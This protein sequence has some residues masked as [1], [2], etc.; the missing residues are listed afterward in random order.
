V[1]G[2]E[3]QQTGTDP[4]R[5]RRVRHAADFRLIEGAVNAECLVRVPDSEW[6][7][8]TGMVSPSHPSGRLPAVHAGSGRVVAAYPR[9]GGDA[10]DTATFG[11][12]APPSPDVFNAHGASLRIGGDGR[13]TLYVVNHGGREAVEVFE[14]ETVGEEAPVVT[15][16]GAVPGPPGADLNNPSAHPDGGFV[17][18][19]VCQGGR[20]S[21]P[22]LWAGDVTGCVLRWTGPGEEMTPIPGTELNAPNGTELSADGSWLF[23]A[24]Y[25][26]H[27]IMRLSLTDHDEPP[28]VTPVDYCPDNFTWTSDGEKLIVL[29]QKVEPKKLMAA[30]PDNDRYDFGFQVL[31]VDPETLEAVVLGEF[32]DSWAGPSTA[33]AVDDEIWVSSPRS[34]SLL[35]VPRTD[36]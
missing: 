35:A 27:E 10:P 2:Q 4:D 23:I 11:D 31:E 17:V 28:L 34:T 26:R 33:L 19:N 29:A 13:H 9:P 1:P 12:I 24:L 5:S 22:A 8:A 30:F 32:D 36:L 16:V 20:E 3:S 25:A 15:W 14:V 6:I 21:Y 18:S 7:L